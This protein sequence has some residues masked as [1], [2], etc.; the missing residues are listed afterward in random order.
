LGP[1]QNDQKAALKLLASQYLGQRKM[2]E[3]LVILRFLID[4][5]PGDAATS[6]ALAYAQIEIQRYEEALATLSQLKDSEQQTVHLLRGKAL[7]QLGL[8]PEA[9]SAF[10]AFRALRAAKAQVSR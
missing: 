2:E 5:A 7:L 8:N 4:H 1:L 9:E 10:A 6:I 3:A